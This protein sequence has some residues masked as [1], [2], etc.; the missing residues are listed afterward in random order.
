[1]VKKIFF[2]VNDSMKSFIL[3][4]FSLYKLKGK[5]VSSESISVDV[6]SHEPLSSFLK[7]NGGDIN[8]TVTMMLL[9]HITIFINFAE[10]KQISIPFIELDDITVVNDKIFLFTGFSKLT[11]INNGRIRIM[12]SFKDNLYYLSP[13]LKSIRST[14][15]DVSY[16]SV[17]YSLALLLSE[18]ILGEKIDK[19]KAIHIRNTLAIIYDTKLYW[20]ISNCLDKNPSNRT[21]T[22]I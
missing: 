5:H 15:T 9:Y 7:R 3:D 17:Y 13:E 14:P 4:V 2:N 21:L 11:P 22:I 12:H 8:Y 1:M 6:S 20:F 18:C 19:N 10:G 16:K